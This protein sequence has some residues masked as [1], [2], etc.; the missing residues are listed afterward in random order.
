MITFRP[1]ANVELLTQTGTDYKLEKH[2]QSILEFNHFQKSDFEQLKNIYE[3]LQP[4]YKEE[5][6]VLFTSYFKKISTT[7]N[8]S[9]TT[10][11]IQSYIENF[12][13]QDRTMTYFQKVMPFFIKI[14]Q[15]GFEMSKV[16][17]LFNQF[18]FYMITH[19]VHTWGLQPNKCMSK[20]PSLQRAINV[21]QQLFFS[22][23][24]ET[25]VESVLDHLYTL[26]RKNTEITFVKD[27]IDQIHQ[28]NMEISSISSTTEELTTSI[29]GV[30][31]YA[32]AIMNK[33]VASVDEVNRMSH[34]LNTA[35]DEILLT[36]STFTNIVDKFNKLQEYV[37][38]IES[39]VKLINDI[40]DQT[41]LLAL[42]ASIEAARAGEH[43]KGFSVVAQEVRKLAESTVNSVQQV[44]DTVNNLK[45]FSKDVA[46]SISETSQIVKHSS[47]DAK[48]SIN[49]LDKLIA[50]IKEISEETTTTAAITEEQAAAID[51]ISNRLNQLS[52]L[53]EDNEVLGKNTGK[54]V[55]EVGQEILKFRT[56]F[57]AS[58]NIHKTTKA[59]LHISK[60]DH[61]LWKWR[62]YNLFLGIGD[63]EVDS[64]ASHKECLLGKWYYNEA[65]KKLFQNSRSFDQLDT[66]HEQVHMHAK[67]AAQLFKQGYK[68]QAEESLAQIEVAS[69]QVINLIN[70]LLSEIKE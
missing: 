29:T 59:V 53:T 45:Y 51:E 62:I 35:L 57:L 28:Q 48:E 11:D 8:P 23:C 22:F 17:V 47:N 5:L 30:A 44:H 40:A 67:K 46:V 2:F 18:N 37:Q 9:I 16:L 26:T 66:Y 4:S 12:F 7:S 15:E 27:L 31:N 33:T 52:L 65:T 41:N 3:T 39:V 24:N 55:Y 43:G 20:L 10:N 25:M 49:E 54:A 68:E 56:N 14:Y 69:K 60:T 19:V 21:D 50:M 70:N 34:L 32:T 58:H 36:E 6:T 38:T 64:I 13:I 1:R 61:L 42:N 63:L